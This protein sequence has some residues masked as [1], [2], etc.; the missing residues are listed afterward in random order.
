MSYERIAEYH[1]ALLENLASNALMQRVIN[2][3]FKREFDLLNAYE[4]TNSPSEIMSHDA[5]GAH[6]LFTGEK[7]KYAFRQTSIAE[8]KKLTWWHKNSQYCWLLAQTYEWFE[9]FVFESHELLL[10]SP[11]KKNTL[12]HSLAYFSSTYPKIKQSEEI[13]ASGIHLKIA[14]LMIEQMRHH[15]VHAQGYVHNVDAFS[16]KIIK[17]S[18]INNSKH[19]NK[20]FFLQ[21]IIDSR[22]YLLER[23]IIDDSKLPRYQDVY[24]HLV[25]YLIGYSELIKKAVEPEQ[26]V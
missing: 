21:F 1:E 19:K 12:S 15:I 7:K 23:P 20:E 13:N 26:V 24:T 25:S 5:F 3:S 17:N 8:L 22:I 18:G 11:R 14:V 16:E 9:K 10:G 4:L 6:D 2:N